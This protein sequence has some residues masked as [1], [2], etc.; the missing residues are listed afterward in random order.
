MDRFEQS[1]PRWVWVAIVAVGI[2]V[3]VVGAIAAR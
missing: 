3:L 2:A 1:F